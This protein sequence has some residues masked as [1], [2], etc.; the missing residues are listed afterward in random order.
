MSRRK[1]NANT[2]EVQID[3]VDEIQS[4]ELMYAP[5]IQMYTDNQSLT[6]MQVD[7]ITGVMQNIEIFKSWCPETS[8]LFEFTRLISQNLQY[9]SF[10]KQ[11]AVFDLGDQGDKFYIILT[12]TAAVYIKRQPQQIETE[13]QE[14][15]PK[16]EQYLEKMQL[17]SISEIESQSRFSFYE[18]LIKKQTKPLKQIESEL[19]LLNT[20]N[21]DMYFTNYGICKFQQISQLH[22]G[23]Y[24][25]DMALTTDKPRAAS[26][27]TISDLQVLS[28]NKSNFKKIFE[29]QIKSQQEKIEYFL[30]MFPTMTKFKISKLIMYF[31]QY[32]YPQ[33]YKIWKQNDLADGFFLL[34]EGEIQLQ[35]TIDFHPFLKQEQNQLPIEPKKDKIVQIDLVT[36]AN[37]T[38]GCFIGETDIYLQNER[39]DYTVKTVSQCIVYVLNHDNYLIVKRQFPEFINPLQLL[40]QKNANLYNKR[41]EEIIQTKILN[42]NLHK[43]EESNIVE[44]RYLNDIEMNQQRKLIKSPQISSPILRS[45]IHPKMTKQQMVEQNQSIAL[46]HSKSD[47]VS[48][49]QEEFN[50]LKM[51]GDNFQK[52]LLIRVEKQFEQFQPTKPKGKTPCFSKHQKDS[53]DLL[54]QIKRNL[55]PKENNQQ[56]E[57][58]YQQNSLPFLTMSKRQFRITSPQIQQKMEILKQCLSNPMSSHSKSV[59]QSVDQFYKIKAQQG[60]VLCDSLH[61]IP[62]HGSTRSRFDKIFTNVKITSRNQKSSKQIW[63]SQKISMDVIDTNFFSSQP[64]VQYI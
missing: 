50:M 41:L 19:L 6:E 25:G 34:K 56:E 24:F 46:Q 61:P 1:T 8:T 52:C 22:S 23:Q 57:P 36:L 29:K 37:L 49:K 15:Q 39:R 14:I 12:G 64:T 16:I 28:L 17:N 3:I 62:D 27:I 33:N 45:S 11:N 51:A 58:E 55:I 4:K 10:Q 60:F 32:K 40:S 21:F 43:R 63:N 47:K 13:E 35:K 5:V 38:D 30:R 44:R 53:K 54:D 26:I 2:K 9:E 20:G 48:N 18:K 42:L 31:S 59:S 7:S